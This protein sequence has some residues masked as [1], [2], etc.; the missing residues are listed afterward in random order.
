MDTIFAALISGGWA[1]AIAGIGFWFNRVSLRSTERN[2]LNT[3]DADHAAHLWDKRA[4][5]YVDT[6]QALTVRR[7]LRDMT[8]HKI[9]GRLKD[10]EEI[11]K[12]ADERQLP[13]WRDLEARLVAYASAE[14]LSVWQDANESDDI[15][16]S[17]LDSFNHPADGSSN[18]GREEVRDAA[19][20]AAEA[21]IRLWDVVQA[22]L[23]RKPSEWAARGPMGLN[24]MR[25]G[26]TKVSGS[27]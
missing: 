19:D 4:E 1:T 17:E 14:V 20:A 5:V 6:L 11:P 10:Q 12:L 18:P 25:L 26:R 27:G 22:D 7:E 3:L 16:F 2:A 24:Q 8:V 21:D 13:D 9:F 15:F 23:H